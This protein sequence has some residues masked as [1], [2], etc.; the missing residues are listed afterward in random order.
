MSNQRARGLG[1]VIA[2]VAA[3]IPVFGVLA[4]AFFAEALAVLAVAFL[5]IAFLA[6]TFFALVAFAVI[7]FVGAMGVV[8]IF[9]NPAVGS[10]VQD[11]TPLISAQAWPV[12]AGP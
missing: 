4:L 2:M 3:A 5:V 1:S 12:F 10:N 6:A 8:R 11:H 7:V 9:A